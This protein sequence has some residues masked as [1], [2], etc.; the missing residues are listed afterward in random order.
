MLGTTSSFRHKHTSPKMHPH[1]QEYYRYLQQEDSIYSNTE[2]KPNP[3]YTSHMKTSIKTS[4]Y[5][6]PESPTG[7]QKKIVSLEL[8]NFNLKEE[9]A[10]LRHALC[11]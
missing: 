5:T 1:M 10:Y 3:L 9:L 11:T 2:P 4:I 8:Q 6:Q 7:Y